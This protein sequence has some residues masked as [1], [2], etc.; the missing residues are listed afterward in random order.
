[1]NYINVTVDIIDQEHICCAI[2]NSTSDN[3]VMSKKDWMKDNFKN[4]LTFIKLDD[5]GKVFIEYIPSEHAYCPIISPNTL[6]INCFWVSGKFVNQGHGTNLLNRCIEDAHN[7]GKDGIVVLS[8]HKKMP[9]LSDPDFL[10]NKGFIVADTLGYFEL[11][12]L[13][14]NQDAPLPKFND[15]VRSLQIDNQEIVIYYTKQCPHSEMYAKIIETMAIEKNVPIQLIKLNTYEDAQNSP[16]PFSTYSFFDKGHFV[17]NE[18]FGP[19]KFEK[20]LESR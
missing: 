17:T 16:A 2:S 19:K 14:L 20:Y 9:F 13:P 11:L 3:R 18:I 5:R 4:G 1:M 12:Y 10:K 8:S 7:R 15:Q 6:F